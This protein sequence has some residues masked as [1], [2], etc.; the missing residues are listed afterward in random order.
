MAYYKNKGNNLKKLD[1]KAI[2]GILVGFNENLY[3]IYNPFSRK[4]V[5][6]RDVHIIENSFMDSYDP[7]NEPKQT[8]QVS[9]N[10]FNYQDNILPKRTNL[11]VTND[12][13]S[14]GIVSNIELDTDELSYPEPI[15]LNKD[16]SIKISQ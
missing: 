8:K 5:W 6:A 12:L 14:S 13:T 15:I 11:N 3:K 7:S 10:T 9:I 2:K 4:S 1:D 16:Q